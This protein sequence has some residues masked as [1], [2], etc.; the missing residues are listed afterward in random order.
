M[1]CARQVT[2]CSEGWDQPCRLY[3]IKHLNISKT[4]N[5][6][7]KPEFSDEGRLYDFEDVYPINQT[8]HVQPVIG[9]CKVVEDCFVMSINSP[10]NHEERRFTNLNWKNTKQSRVQKDRN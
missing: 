4:S 5:Q 3:S 8:F 9:K 10:T 6:F 7:P 1:F 2:Y